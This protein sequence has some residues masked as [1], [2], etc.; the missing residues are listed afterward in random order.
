MKRTYK[1]IEN[2]LISILMPVYNSQEFLA[3]SINSI[4]EQTYKNFEL[5]CVD[6]GSTDR[7]FELLEFYSKLDERIKLIIF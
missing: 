7:S 5:I 3:A 4:L 6:D 2:P 1:T